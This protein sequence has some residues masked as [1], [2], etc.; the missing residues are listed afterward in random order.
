LFDATAPGGIADDQRRLGIA[1]E[2]L[3]FRQCVSCVE[4]KIDASHAH[5]REV[6][7]ESRNGL[8]D[9]DSNRLPGLMP[10][11]ASTLAKRPDRAMSSA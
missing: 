8:L 7:D 1:D 11:A 2:I 4:G 10:R 6:K 3:Q 5:R 9:L